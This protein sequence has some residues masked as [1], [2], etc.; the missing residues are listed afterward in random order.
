MSLATRPITGSE[1]APAIF[2]A[3]LFPAT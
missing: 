1:A 3:F 2:R